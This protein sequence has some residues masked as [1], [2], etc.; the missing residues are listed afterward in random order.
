LTTTNEVFK[1]N[2]VQKIKREE[3]TVQ[4]N[5]FNALLAEKGYNK[6]SLSKL[7]NIPYETLRG[8]VNGRTNFTTSEVVV[9]AKCLGIYEDPQRIKDIF[10]S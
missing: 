2:I 6:K 5:L 1:I 8:K 3:Q 7:T 4:K 10:L 9:I